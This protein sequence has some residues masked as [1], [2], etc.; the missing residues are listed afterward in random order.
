MAS[1]DPTYWYTIVAGCNY[2]RIANS[3]LLQET[4]KTKAAVFAQVTDESSAGQKWQFWPSPHNAS[5]YL[6]RGGDA[7]PDAYLSVFK[8]AKQAAVTGASDA[9][10]V[11]MWLYNLTTPS[12]ITD[13]SA[14]TE[15]NANALWTIQPWDE[16]VFKLETF[17]NGTNWNLAVNGSNSLMYMDKN[18]T[19]NVRHQCQEFS[20][21][22]GN[23]IND[24]RY[25][26][27][28]INGASSVTTLSIG[29][30]GTMVS[31]GATPSSSPSNHPA[32]NGGNSTSSNSTGTKVGIAVGVM[33]GVC[34]LVAMMLG[35]WF[36][37][38]RRS[39]RRKAIQVDEAAKDSSTWLHDAKPPNYPEYP[40]APR[41]LGDNYCSELQGGYYMP[42]P[43]M[44]CE[45]MSTSMP[46][47]LG[48][49]KS[50]VESCSTT[51]YHSAPHTALR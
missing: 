42:H 36:V 50:P 21:A 22:K 20:I 45:A 46:A 7:G 5:Y 8:D 47:E 10:G 16:L 6:L 12:A 28:K 31:A 49:V 14:P 32:G 9:S 43:P 38:R 19:A 24:V 48:A 11:S 23:S 27:L 17:A 25:S 51:P 44:P 15:P 30:Q 3:V 37:L 40:Q 1:F 2:Q 33:I 26:T 41:E 18:T 35:V 13:P 34:A 4:N 29:T 39:Q